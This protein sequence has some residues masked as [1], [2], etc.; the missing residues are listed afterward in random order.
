MQNIIYTMYIPCMVSIVLN[1][2]VL[3]QSSTLVGKGAPSTPSGK[4][5]RVTPVH[6]WGKIL[7]AP[8][9]VEK[10]LGATIH[11]LEKGFE[12]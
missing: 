11:L 8:V 5:F 7:G 3:L 4:R 6:W 2:L 12:Y 1:P 10:V 9:Q